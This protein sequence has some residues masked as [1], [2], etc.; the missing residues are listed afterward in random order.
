MK[1]LYTYTN[2]KDPL[3][4]KNSNGVQRILIIFQDSQKTFVYFCDDYLRHT[5]LNCL[6][7]K[8]SPTE[9]ITLDDLGR[10]ES[11]QEFYFYTAWVEQNYNYNGV[12]VEDKITG[13][14]Q[15]GAVLIDHLGNPLIK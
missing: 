3:V 9:P 6:K 7:K 13:H 1:V 5:Y 12:H 11:D 8:F 2:G 15:G 10:I 14:D 4:I